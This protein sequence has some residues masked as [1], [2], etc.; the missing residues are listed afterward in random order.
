[1]VFTFV[2]VVHTLIAIA[3]VAVILLQKSEGGALG[4]GSGPTGFLSA[5]GAGDVLTRS[6]AILATMFVATSIVLAVLAGADRKQQPI[7]TTLARPAAE[8][9]AAPPP[10]P[11]TDVPLAQ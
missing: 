9:P 8:A 11:V 1:M 6:T 5:R 3:L 10:A 2:L 4:I 7:D